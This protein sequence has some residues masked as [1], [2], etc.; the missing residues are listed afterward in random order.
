MSRFVAGR[1]VTQQCDSPAAGL[2]LSGHRL[3]LKTARSIPC[4]DVC[5]CGWEIHLIA[6][7][8]RNHCFFSLRTAPVIVCS[9]IIFVLPRSR[10]WN[11]MLLRLA[12]LLILFKAWSPEAAR[13]TK[14]LVHLGARPPVIQSSIRLSAKLGDRCCHHHLNQQLDNSLQQKFGMRLGWQHKE[15]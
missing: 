4:C 10:L 2:C 3:H 8:G 6:G 15:I 7:S 1:A 9:C 13:T 14:K 11:N 5:V 12:R